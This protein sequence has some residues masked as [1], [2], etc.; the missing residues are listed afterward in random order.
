MGILNYLTISFQ[1]VGIILYNFVFA[2]KLGA[3]TESVSNCLTVKAAKHSIFIHIYIVH[4]V[5]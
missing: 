3:K 1:P 4:P 2:H 5:L